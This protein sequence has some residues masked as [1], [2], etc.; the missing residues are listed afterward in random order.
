MAARERPD[1]AEVGLRLNLAP[2]TRTPPT[3]LGRCARCGGQVEGRI[4][5]PGDTDESRCIQCG[6]S[7]TPANVEVSYTPV[8]ENE[9][10]PVA[11]AQ[12][13]QQSLQSGGVASKAELARQLGVTR[14]HVTQALGLLLLAS[15]ARDA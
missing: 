15:E 11:L 5:F 3:G 12:E 8:P 13:W 4:S 6:R 14:D 2:K 9:S 10:L 7:P 1:E